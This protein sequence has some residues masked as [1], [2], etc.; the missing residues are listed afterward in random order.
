MK[1][2]LTNGCFD[3]L[4]EGHRHLIREAQKQC[5]RLLVALNSDE[6][7]RA[8]KGEGRPLDP[9]GHRAMKVLACL[10]DNDFV[11]PFE[12]EADL[13]MV[14]ELN[15][16]DVIFKGAEYEGQHVTGDELVPVVLIPM[17]GDY[18]TTNEIARARA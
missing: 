2:G 11:V 17:L 13:L 18:S 4:H 5:D 1:T 14:I 8:L 6:S 10:R 15:E 7:V 12:D 3:L 16:P 9:L